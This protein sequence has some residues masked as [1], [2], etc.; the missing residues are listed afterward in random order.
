MK[1]GK[2]LVIPDVHLKPWMFDKAT[3]LMRKE[4][5]TKAVCLGD[6]GDEFDMGA[7][8]G[9]YNETY[10]KLMRFMETFPEALLCYG[11]HEMSYKW[12]QTST[13]GYSPYAE[14]TVL[15][16][17][18]D[19]RNK[20]GDRVAYIHRVGN[21]IFSHAG[22]VPAWLDE[23][24]PG[25]EAMYIDDVITRT[26]QMGFHQM[27]TDISSIWVRPDSSDFKS[28]SD[29][30]LQV[31]GH[32]PQKQPTLIN[33]ILCCDTFSTKSDGVT[34]YGSQEF[35]IINPDLTWTAVKAEDI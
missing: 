7:D 13:S 29:E 10:Y 35:V 26:N 2:V 17:L 33:G 20:F 27:W 6:Y 31:C 22:L 5:I 8:I 30:Y 19:L 9:A 21:G 18:I 28:F 1:N 4:D 11:N 23:W 16:W 32:T 3:D 24:V 34:P 14:I 25:W 15:S 12:R